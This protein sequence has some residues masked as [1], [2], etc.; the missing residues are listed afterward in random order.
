MNIKCIEVGYLQT[1]CYIVEKNSDVLIIDPG[2]EADKIISNI[3]DFNVKAILITHYHFDHIGALEILRDKY[4]VNI[5]DYNNAGQEF[6]IGE[7]DF[8]VISTKGHTDDSVTFYFKKEKIMFTGDFLF[9]ESIGRTDFKNS[10][11][12]DMLN[13]I[14]LIK[15][16]SD[17]ISIYPGHGESSTLLHERQN[18]IFYNINK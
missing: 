5:I 15:K 9:K 12:D 10:N 18:N 11:Y 4:R 3:G 14:E 6:N 7:F 2:D 16:Y 1:N 13:S 8:K 17:D